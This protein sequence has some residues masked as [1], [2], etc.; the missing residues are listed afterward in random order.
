VAIFEIEL[1]TDVS[2][3]T[4]D[5]SKFT[6][7]LDSKFSKLSSAFTA[8]GGV[9]AGV[10]A[11]IGVGFSLKSAIDEAAQY[12]DAVNGLAIAL[13]LTGIESGS[14]VSGLEEFAAGIQETTRLSDDAVLSS[15]SLLQSIARLS[16]E[17]LKKGT[18]AAID[19]SAALRIDLESATRLVGKAAEGNVDAFKRYGIEIRKGKN[20]AETFSNTLETLNE[21]FG[22]S[23][24]AATDTYAGALDQLKNN[25][26]DV[27]KQVG[28]GIIQNKEFVGSIKS[29]SKSL[30]DIIPVATKFGVFLGKAI[31]SSLAAIIKLG[32]AIKNLPVTILETVTGRKLPKAQAAIS[33]A[34]SKS[35][36][37]SS[38]GSLFSG[39]PRTDFEAIKK[40]EEARTKSL[41][42]EQDERDKIIKEQIKGEEEQRKKLLGTVQTLISFIGQGAQGVTGALATVTSTIVDTILPGF[43]GVAAQL[44]SFLAQGPEAVK[45]QIQSFIDNIPVIIDNVI[46]AIPAVI[47]ALAANSGKIIS[48]LAFLMPKVAAS[49]AIALVQELPNIA[50]AFVD[51]LISEA[52]RLITALV[53]GVK[54]LFG[55]V[56][57]GVSKGVKGI[58]KIFKFAEG[59]VVPG[60]AP[61]TDRVP[62][63]LSPGEV[64]LNRQQVS[65]LASEK[66]GGGG[67][68]AVTINLMIG[69]EQLAS[70][71]VNLSRQGFRMA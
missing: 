43:G 67:S 48:A 45:A 62:A 29:I 12:E 55:N 54:N 58:G 39:A 46:A 31:A 41:L 27:L 61:Y 32:E 11:A 20:D 7:S 68:Q 35:G 50:K 1:L 13:K 18:Q 15:A 2:K 40:A 56:G 28:L 4:K 22:G 30:V 42:K 37:S 5:I 51:G 8:L 60:G 52:G 25:F 9:V 57:G 6:S 53:D 63:L 64:V 33:E 3:A 17:G 14:A 21:R 19:L 66:N 38:G 44:F 59:G 65:Q 10:A 34:S 16:E 69:E 26:S 70:V 36:T 47:E 24:V 71:L 49:L 23:A